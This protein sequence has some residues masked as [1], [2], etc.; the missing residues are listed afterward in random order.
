[1]GRRPQINFSSLWK[2]VDFTKFSTLSLIFSNL[3]VI[4]FA[5][6]DKLSAIDVLW[7]YWAQSVIIGLFNFVKMVTLKEFTTTGIKQGN[8][9][10]LATRATKFSMAVFFLFHYGFFHFI[11]AVFL[12]SFSTFGISGSNG[13][14]SGYFLYSTGMFF[15]SYLIEFINSKNEESEELPNIGKIMFAPYARIIPMHLTIIFGGFIAAAGSTFSTDTNLTIIVLFIGIKT[16]VDLLT[17]SI[18]FSSLKKQT[19]EESNF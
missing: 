2:Q 7:I 13:F 12:G 17:H 1:M 14:Q 6:V 5:V 16:L 4:I 10:P 3:L 15:I 9:Q 18:S 11:Y 19:V 8:K